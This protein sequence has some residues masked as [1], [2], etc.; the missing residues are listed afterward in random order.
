M[1]LRARVAVVALP[2]VGASEVGAARWIS[3]EDA[4]S[5]AAPKRVE[6]TTR[7]VRDGE[8]AA[9][10]AVPDEA[11]YAEIAVTLQSLV[12]ERTG[13]RLPIVPARDLV[14]GPAG[15]F[16]PDVLKPRSAGGRHLVLLGDLSSNPAVA[17]L[18]VQ[19]QA[20]EDAAYPGAGGH[21]VR[22]VVDPA[23]LGWNAV[24]LGGPGP[25]E[26]D[27]AA[28]RFADLLSLRDGHA[29][30]PYCLEVAFGEHPF[31]GEIRRRTESTR[32]ITKNTAFYLLDPESD[33]YRNAP[34]WVPWPG[35]QQPVAYVCDI[36]Y[37]FLICPGLH[38]GLTGDSE[39]AQAVGRGLDT[40]YERMDW[41]EANRTAPFDDHYL[42]EAWARAWQQVV[43]CPH[44][45]PEQRARGHKVMAFLAGQ[46]AMYRFDTEAYGTTNE[47]VLSRHAYSGKFAGDALCRVVQRHTDVSGKLAEVIAENRK[48]F[49][50]MVDGMLGTYMTGFDHKWGLDGSFHLLQ[51]AAEEPREPYL[52]DGMAQLTADYATMC[53]NNAG[54]FV[55]FGA[56]NIGATERY[57][58]YQIL[59]RAELLLRDGTYQWWLDNRM[60][61]QPYKIFISSMN[62]L[63]HWFHTRLAAREPNH[64]V[65]LN[66]LPLS[67]LIY[68]DWV[69]GRVH[70]VA[71]KPVLNSVP[72]Q[73]AFNKITFR[74]GLG[75]HDQYLMLDGLGGQAYSGNDANGICEYSRLGQPL[76]VQYTLRHEPYYQNT[77][78]VS[79]G[80]LGEPAGT[81]AQVLDMADFPRL[82]YT[83]TRVDPLCGSNNVRHLFMEHGRYVV[84][85]DDVTL[86]NAGEQVVAC[87]F[88]GFG[89]PQLDLPAGTW[90]LRQ[91]KADLV[92]QSVPVP[93]GPAPALAPSLRSVY[94]RPDGWSI[95]V[96]VL[97]QTIGRD[98][99]AGD[100]FRFANLFY[101]VEPA[102]GTPYTA[103]ALGPDAVVVSGADHGAVFAVARDGTAT[104]G[105]LE[106]AA[107]ALR[108]GAETC[109]FVG[110][111][112]VELR[113]RELFRCRA[114]VT[115]AV[116]L[117]GSACR[118][119]SREH[120]STARRVVWDP[121]WH[122]DATAEQLEAGVELPTGERVAFAVDALRTGVRDILDRVRDRAAR[123]SA[124]PLPSSSAPRLTVNAT[125]ILEG[126][127]APVSATAWA[128]LDGDGE[129][130]FLCAR[131]DGEI[132]GVRRDGESPLRIS[133]SQR[134]LISVWAGQLNGLPR[135]I[136]GARNGAVLCYDT[137]GRL[138]WRY[139]N[140]HHGY[141][142]RLDVYSIGVGET[143]DD[144]RQQLVLGCHGV[145]VLVDVD[146]EPTF[147]RSTEV[148]AHKVAP[149][150]MIGLHDSRKQWALCNTMSSGLMLIDPARGG[151]AYGWLRRWNSTAEYAEP[152]SFGTED[153]W[154]VHAGANG[155]GCGRLIRDAWGKGQRSQALIWGKES[156]Y[157]L[158]GSEIS[159]ATVCDLDGDGVPEIVTGNEAGFLT[160]YDHLGKELW[161]KLA[162]CPPTAVAAADVDGDGRT[163]LLVGGNEPGLTA[164][165]AE[166]RSLGQWSEGQSVSD[167]WVRQGT[168]FVLTPS[169]TLHR[170]DF[171]RPGG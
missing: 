104:V 127:A 143:Q 77:I 27:A 141:G 54:E 170:L 147:V 12:T 103:T 7:L 95:D 64:L 168:V 42:V 52:T 8:T 102:R 18:Y 32:K 133:T 21:T 101:G 97:R 31:L 63:G 71:G 161:R 100:A 10:I 90:R 72:F 149:L 165:S 61:R 53:I 96:Q 34:R 163:E 157:L 98:F 109:H 73:D 69:A 89:E 37:F 6:M 128:D 116:A 41:V 142:S 65:G 19:W 122:T 2:L 91:D 162:P 129:D 30:V 14:V 13:V 121:A 51:A 56:E 16:A 166:L 153:T 80:N 47:R 66:R 125:P 120:G 67:R 150:R 132:V 156:W 92:L 155:V 151:P 55:N 169:G 76:L 114:P 83:R 130:E 20:F 23:G 46:T 82:S 113:G 137:A 93:G 26:V 22:T 49:G 15:R 17:R 43:N 111:T 85:F 126:T 110:V 81:F 119:Q 160:G 40:L 57:D 11:A 167:L 123:P 117:D 68:E 25:P 75:E 44:L 4:R 1:L 38:Y 50:V 105:D 134:G 74:D 39:F 36:L 84:V 146:G 58:A 158:T 145:V 108:L 60:K 78:S 135:V 164:L 48:I 28:R 9:V 118:V 87:T 3:W 115:L 79:K 24:V 144:S 131:E 152:R 139:R 35:R 33:A 148:H 171:T 106:A 62:W 154:F 45:T 112:R 138:V 159:S 140:R 86:H 59:G 5:Q 88:R 136:C 70:A 94:T 29:S 99:R 107:S 124:A